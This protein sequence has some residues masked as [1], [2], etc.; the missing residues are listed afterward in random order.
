M[1]EYL[2]QDSTLEDIADAIRSKNGSSDTYTPAEM[3]EA[4]AEIETGIEP[5][6][7]SWDQRPALVASYL[8]N[9][10]YDPSDY[11]TS[12]IANYA[13]ATADQ[14][15]TKPTGKTITTQGG[16]L[17]R[18]G[19]RQ[20]IASGNTTMYNDIPN[21]YT[22]FSVIQNGNVT[23]IGL[24]HPT[25]SL[26]WINTVH[27]AWNC[28]DLGGW[29]CDGGTIKYGKL[30]RGGNPGTNDK[31]VLLEQLG[32]KYELDLRGE[33]EASQ[34]PSVLK[35]YIGYSVFDNY[36]W[37]TLTNKMLWKKILRVVF[38]CVATSRPIYFHCAAGA[39]RTGTLACIIE[40]ILGVS[41]SD[42][43][44]DYELTSFY[45][46][47]NNDNNARRRNETEWTGLIGEIN[48][49]TGSTFRDKAVN[50]VASL[51]FTAAEIN[52]FRAAMINGT[53][54]AVTPSVRTFTI[55]KTLTQAT[56]SNAATTATEFQPYETDV[57]PNS[58]YVISTVS[59]TMGGTDITEEVWSGEETEQYHRVS[60]ALTNCTTTNESKYV[61]D[62][63]SYI[64][65][66]TPNEGY[67]LDG[68]TVSITMGG[69]SVS[70]Y[71]SSGTI[72][73]P[74]VTGDISISIT[75]V[76]AVV[77]IVNLI[78]T[79][80]IA[81][82]TRLSTSDGGNRTGANGHAT[83]GATADASGVIS[84]AVGD[85]IRIKGMT[86]PSSQDTMVAL[87]R[88]T[89]SGGFSSAGYF[90]KGTTSSGGLRFT[91][92]DVLTV[93]AVSQEYFRLSAIC[94]DTS[95]VVV[96]RNQEIS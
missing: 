80:G 9:V 1:A 12:Q 79:I 86:I 66:I 27:Q 2:I 18:D 22:P 48:A 70:Q 20:T 63:G 21:Q 64:A 43:D 62:G 25:G 95:A 17:D 24:L 33:T 11:T 29:A 76:E 75:A 55:T 94:S 46:G 69:V 90:T 36:A 38:D 52:A 3:A 14:S 16:T 7:F 39:D 77:P 47:T 51:G 82:N 23:N 40:A 60:N 73:I 30:F 31:P 91:H 59:V 92:G 87:V 65:T 54:E 72:A 83:I 26:R 13:P 93:T 53:P 78:D 37:Y 19:F 89:S 10:T 44:K 32:I 41:Q 56:L 50:F 8:D 6:I 68:A 35:D 61:A 74:Q 81:A 58:G 28:R 15:N 84:V 96:T 57:S 5:Q 42:I 88:C 34:S 4:I 45:S 67:T 85:T 49:Y 71:Y